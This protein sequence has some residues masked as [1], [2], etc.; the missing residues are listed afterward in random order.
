MLA[1]MWKK[2]NPCTLLVGMWI[3]IASVESGVRVPQ[4][5]KNRNIKWYIL[6]YIS[7]EKMKILIWKDTCNPIVHSSIIYSSQYVEVDE[8]TKMWYIPTME[9]YS[10]I[11]KEWNSAIL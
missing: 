7:E 6:G 2:G 11:N 5:T 9:Y 1:R 3:G 10:T 8:C 4:K